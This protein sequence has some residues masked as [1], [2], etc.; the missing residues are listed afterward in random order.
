MRTRW[1]PRTFAIALIAG[2]LSAC[3][4]QPGPGYY[5]AYPGGDAY[6]VAPAYPAPAYPAYTYPAYA[7]PAP[8]YAP[9]PFV[10][11]LSLSF[12]DGRRGRWR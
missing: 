2:S 4:Y 8:V 6:A 5:A 9:A 12:G 11:A 10:G 3:V 1:I 7:Y